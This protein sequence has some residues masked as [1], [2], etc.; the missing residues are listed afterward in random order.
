MLCIVGLMVILNIILATI[1]ISLISLIGVVTLYFKQKFLNRILFL[2][3]SLSIGA[4]LG[5]AFLHLIPEAIEM[6]SSVFIFV[7]VGFF[8][9]FIIEKFFHWR[10]C[11]NAKCEVHSFAYINL[12]GDAIHNFIDGIII[13]AGFLAGGLVGISSVIA[14]ALHE[15]PQELGDFGVLVYA[16]FSRLKALKWNFIISLT[17]LLGGIL[18]FYLLSFF[19]SLMPFLLAIAAGGFIYISASD[20]LPEI[21]KHNELGK[22]MINLL[23]ILLGIGIMYL[24]KFV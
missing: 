10:H 11:H 24:L 18:G 12:F 6:N 1:I 14:I 20:L 4:L 8:S 9:F 5:G 19:N 3:I 17:S 23:F 22:V 16:G 2:L 15:I 21:K 7:L 13:A